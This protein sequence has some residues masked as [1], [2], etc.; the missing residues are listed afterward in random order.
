M[1]ERRRLYANLTVKENLLMGAYLRKD[2]DGIKADLEKMYQL[3]PFLRERLKQYAGT[4][5][6]RKQWWPSPGD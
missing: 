5:S 3:F 4:L 2:N 1:P 6:G